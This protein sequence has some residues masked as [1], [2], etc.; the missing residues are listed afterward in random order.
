MVAKIDQDLCDLC[1][2]FHTQSTPTLRCVGI[3]GE[4]NAILVTYKGKILRGEEFDKLHS[5]EP[6]PTWITEEVL[7]RG[8]E[9]VEIDPEVCTNC[10]VCVEACPH[11]AIIPGW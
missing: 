1:C 3:C 7:M 4:D 5:S 9:K 11:E 10:N 8:I 6:R 2:G